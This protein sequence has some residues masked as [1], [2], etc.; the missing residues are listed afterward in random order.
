MR[1]WRFEQFVR[2]GFN[3]EL[4][5][6]LAESVEAARPR[7]EEHGIQLRVDADRVPSSAGDPDRIGQALDNLVSNAV[8][9]TDEG[10]VV[11]V[12][13]DGDGDGLELVVK[14]TGI[15]VPS[16][17][18]GQEFT[19]FFRASTATKRA[20][21][22]TGILVPQALEGEPRGLVDAWAAA[23]RRAVELYRASW[24]ADPTRMIAELSEWLPREM[25][26]D[27]TI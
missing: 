15:G 20:I 7:A 22:G 4:S 6:A 10:G 26:P 3:T 17:E 2:L 5:S 27:C 8:K 12:T 16:E 25:K 18:Q 13:V 11:R 9:F 23:A 14:D 21:P 1:S 24:E 19:R